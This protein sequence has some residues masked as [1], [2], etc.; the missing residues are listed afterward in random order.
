[1]TPPLQHRA[2]IRSLPGLLIVPA[3]LASC[4]GSGTQISGATDSLNAGYRIEGQAV[5]LVNG[6]SEIS[7]APGSVAKVVSRAMDLSLP[8]D[9][10]AGNRPDLVFDLTQQRGGSGTFVYVV[11]ALASESG[12][13][14]SNDFLLGRP[15][16]GC[17]VCRSMPTRCDSTQPALPHKQNSP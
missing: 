2:V 3:F 15:E 12:Y 8:Q 13:L 14:G 16:P 6:S 7:A 1:M 9:L 17:C 11:A 5:L 4:G 10:N